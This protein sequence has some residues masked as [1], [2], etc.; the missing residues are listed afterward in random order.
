MSSRGTLP[1]R[2]SGCGRLASLSPSRLKLSPMNLRR[3]IKEVIATVSARCAVLTDN[4]S[5]RNDV[6]QTGHAEP[7]RSRDVF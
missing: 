3:C 4:Y 2:L 5:A 7:M 6:K 1:G